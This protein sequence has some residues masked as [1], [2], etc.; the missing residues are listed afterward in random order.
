MESMFM[1][2]PKT[3]TSESKAATKLSEADFLAQ[4]ADEARRAIAHALHD[5][6]AALGEGMDPKEW[7]RRYPLVAVGSAIAA[8]FVTA[9]LTIPSK[10]QQELRRMERLHRA[11]NPPPPAPAKPATGEPT[12]AEPPRSIWMIILR[13][14]IQMI[15][16]VLMSALTAG[17]A[18]HRNGQAGHD[19]Q[20][21][22]SPGSKPV[23]ADNPTA[24]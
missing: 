11:M 7:T 8:G 1:S 9:L 4:Q 5:A 22:E 23:G 6:K 20:H 10:E 12:K 15:R 14:A 18:A 19:G 16:P 17:L 2:E 21:P 24:Q 3:N 13:E